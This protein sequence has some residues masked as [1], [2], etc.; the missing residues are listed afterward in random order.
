MAKSQVYRK[1]KK[2][3]IINKYCVCLGVLSECFLVFYFL[4]V[5]LCFF[6]FF[7]FVF[8]VVVL[9]FSFKY[10]E[11]KKSKNWRTIPNNV[12]N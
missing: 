10:Y 6:Y 8:V 9:F 7:V 5:C 1:E 4:F 2:D 12:V 11:S 3:K